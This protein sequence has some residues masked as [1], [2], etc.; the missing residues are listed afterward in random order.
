MRQIGGEWWLAEVA[1]RNGY[2]D[3]V[4]DFKSKPTPSEVAKVYWA[5]RFGRPC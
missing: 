1:Y 2:T 5:S 4:T 3:L